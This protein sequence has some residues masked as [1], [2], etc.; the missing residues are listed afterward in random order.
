MFEDFEY[1]FKKHKWIVCLCFLLVYMLGITTGYT[2]K[3]YDYALTET[4]QP[5]PESNFIIYDYPLTEEEVFE[6]YEQ[7]L[8]DKWYFTLEVDEYEISKEKVIEIIEEWLF[9]DTQPW[10]A[11]YRTPP[12]YW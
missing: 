12:E 4:D 2:L 1:V 5:E 7:Y 10:D 6:R 9:E 3:G 8:N 11:E